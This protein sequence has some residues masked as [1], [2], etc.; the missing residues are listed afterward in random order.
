M[1]LPAPVPATDQQLTPTLYEVIAN[2]TGLSNRILLLEQQVAHGDQTGGRDYK[3][4]A[5]VGFAAVQH[6]TDSLDA[7]AHWEGLQRKH[8]QGLKSAY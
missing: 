4:D 3:T 7:C 8:L 1:A 5:G 6:V 2:V